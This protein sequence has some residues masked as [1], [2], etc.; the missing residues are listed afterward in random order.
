MYVAD[1]FT[2]FPAFKMQQSVGAPEINQPTKNKQNGS[3][4]LAKLNRQL[5]MYR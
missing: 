4:W 5:A 1:K 3:N 2:K